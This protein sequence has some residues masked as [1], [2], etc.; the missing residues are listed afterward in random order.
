M[1][2]IVWQIVLNAMDFIIKTFTID[3][4]I[5]IIPAFFVAG[6]IVS[7]LSRQTIMKYLGP[8]VSKPIAYTIATLSG[9][10]LTT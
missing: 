4:I 1:L 5:A 8:G 6:A 2:E 10:A 9:I 7:F 3:I